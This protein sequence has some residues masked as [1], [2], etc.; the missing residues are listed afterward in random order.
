MAEWLNANVLKAFVQL[1]RG[2]K[3]LSP[4]NPGGQTGKVIG[5]MLRGFAGSSPALDIFSEKSLGVGLRMFL[6]RLIGFL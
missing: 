2:F 6:T 4:F 5:L 1:Y 3:S